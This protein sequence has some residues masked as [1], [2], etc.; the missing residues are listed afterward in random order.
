MQVTFNL[1]FVKGLFATEFRQ[2][3]KTRTRHIYYVIYGS[4]RTSIKQWLG[5]EFQRST[6]LYQV[7]D[8]WGKGAFLNA[9]MNL[10]VP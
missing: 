5:N 2:F 10:R 7:R 6:L 4:D 8:R 9:E 3:Q 1:K